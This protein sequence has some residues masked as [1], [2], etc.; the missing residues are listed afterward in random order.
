VKAIKFAPEYLNLIQRGEKVTTWR[1][2]QLGKNCYPGPEPGMYPQD[3]MREFAPLHIAAK[4]ETWGGQS[5]LKVPFTPGAAFNFEDWWQGDGL[6]ERV[7]PIWDKGEVLSTYAGIILIVK[8]VTVRRL[9][10][11][12]KR[13][14]QDDGFES[15]KDFLDAWERHYPNT[16]CTDPWC[17]VLRFRLVQEADK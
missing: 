12:T 10:Q 4:H 8:T 3:R 5:V 13:A 2:A 15:G 9:S 16:A 1:L 6:R 7:R 17:W 11:A 14:A